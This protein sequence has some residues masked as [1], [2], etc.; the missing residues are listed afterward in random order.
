[1]I[2]FNTENK[3]KHYIKHKNALCKK[4]QYDDSFMFYSIKKNKVLRV[5][6]WSCGCGC[7]K[8]NTMAQVVGKIKQTNNSN[9]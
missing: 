4:A 6:G 7:G 2:V 8:G 9:N 1:M 5:S 3:A